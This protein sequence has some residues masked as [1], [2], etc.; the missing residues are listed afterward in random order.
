MTPF[1]ATEWDLAHM[2]L[3]PHLRANITE[4]YLEGGHMPYVDRKGL[5]AMRREL[6]AFYEATITRE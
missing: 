3:E 4:R 6:V 5:A 2:N 1:F